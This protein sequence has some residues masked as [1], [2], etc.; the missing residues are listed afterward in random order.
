M[1]QIITEDGHLVENLEDH[2]SRIGLPEIGLDYHMVSI[3][4]CQSSGKSTLL[5]LLFGTK[6]ETMDEGRGR[7]QTTKGI[8]A[9]IAV[10]HPLLVFDVEGCDSRERGDADALFE[11]K[12]SLFALSLSE[13]MIVNMWE[14]DIGRY[15]AANL[16]M[17]RTVFEVNIQLFQ[18]RVE[19][20]TTLLFLIRDYTTD[21]FEALTKNIFND[22]SNIWKD[23]NLPAEYKDSKIDDFFDFKFYAI[24]H[25]KIQRDIFDQD[26]EKLKKWFCDPNDENYLFKESSHKNV[27][28][29]GLAQYIASLWNVIYENKELNIPSQRS[30]LSHF[31]CEENMK[32]AVSELIEKL[33]DVLNAPLKKKQMI[34][35]FRDV[36]EAPVSKAFT[37]YKEASW[38]YIPEVVEEKYEEMKSQ[39]NDFLYPLFNKNAQILADKVLVDFIAFVDDR[40]F[41]FKQGGEW[42]NQVELSRV[43][44]LDGLKQQINEMV[45]PPFQWEYDFPSLER[46]MKDFVNTRKEN[47]VDNLHQST[48]ASVLHSFH[49]KAN[50][51]LKEADDNMWQQLRTLM[52]SK[53]QETTNAIQSILDTNAPGEKANPNISRKYEEEALNLVKESA[54]Y[55]LL[56]MKTA[57]DKAF[58]Y[59]NGRPRIW[60]KDDDV[61]YI[62]EQAKGKGESVLRLFTICKLRDPNKPLTEQ[63][64]Q[65]NEILIDNDKSAELL[66][67]YNRIIKHIY[68]ETQGVIKAQMTQDHIPPFAWMLLLLI[69][70]D[71]IIK[72]LANPLILTFALFFGGGYFMLN[73]LGLWDVVYEAGKERI[74]TIISNLKGIDE[75][76]EEEEETLDEKGEEPSDQK[77]TTHFEEEDAPDLSKPLDSLINPE[78]PPEPQ[79]VVQTENDSSE[80][81]IEIPMPPLPTGEDELPTKPQPEVHSSKTKHKR[82][83]SKP[84][85]MKNVPK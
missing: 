53:S 57:F 31:K 22:M 71:K 61:N 58:K 12:A 84:K 56:K 46:T 48:F 59:E 73:Q 3:I 19:S 78:V 82:R 35:N 51:I 32:A 23:I 8:H 34:S 47:L 83:T 1:E 17:L 64:P 55:V 4:G 41:E 36:C 29:D 52:V 26:V 66:E 11:R 27:P 25:M 85:T 21:N 28:G 80:F 2:I 13:I 20:K 76:G 24:H 10:G 69:G 50:E 70:G 43:T 62:F 67:T 77:Q 37:Q 79:A 42:F 33:T 7:Q 45:V 68:E 18:A 5:N 9:S 16:P 54:Q 72:W 40:G 65:L 44:M 49:E 38:R 63:D 30:M 15:N 74:N 60:T 14:S 6:F 39:I 75:E 81:N